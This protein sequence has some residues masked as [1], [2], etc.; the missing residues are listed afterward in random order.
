MYGNL[1]T[2]YQFSTVIN[3]SSNNFY[4]NQIHFSIT[5]LLKFNASIVIIFFTFDL[6]E[7]HINRKLTKLLVNNNPH[8]LTSSV[9]IFWEGFLLSKPPYVLDLEPKI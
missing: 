7:N 4:F 1:I 2:D 5:G 9:T 3:L 6:I 8:A